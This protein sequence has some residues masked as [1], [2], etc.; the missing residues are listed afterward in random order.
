[1]KPDRSNY[2]LW[3]IDWLDGNLDEARTGQLMEFLQENP[4]LKEEADSL[5]LARLNP[6]MNIS[7]TK[8]SLKRYPADLPLS[9]VEY[10]SIAFLENDLSAAQAGELK[11]SISFS[12]GNRKLFDSIQKT[13]LHP[14]DYN[15]RNK[16]ALLRKTPGQKAYRLVIRSLSAAAAATI[17]MATLFSLTHRQGTDNEIIAESTTD[18][19]NINQGN[20]IIIKEELALNAAP[21]NKTIAEIALTGKIFNEELAIISANDDTTSLPELNPDM[22]ITAIPVPYPGFSSERTIN[23]LV[24]PNIAIREPEYYDPDRGRIKRFLAS[25]FRTKILKDE[26]Y[27]DA[28]LQPYEIAEAGIEGLNNLLGWRM[29]LV[30]TSDEEGELQSLYF[31]SKVLKFNAPVKKPDTSL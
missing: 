18:T 10:L 16:K 24:S 30:K 25:T 4:D 13:K 7:V 28:P 23:T 14:E 27:N 8:T 22:F 21:V 6:D 26:S 20:A 17:I 2:E 19:I 29:A 9:Q 15:F 31:S 12:P 11:E 1:M 3:L 5:S